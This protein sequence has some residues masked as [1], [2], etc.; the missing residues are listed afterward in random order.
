LGKG[1]PFRLGESF[2]GSTG[3]RVEAGGRFPEATAQMTVAVERARARHRDR[4]ETFTGETKRREE[5]RRR[6]EKELRALPGRPA[7]MMKDG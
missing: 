3:F 5:R 6:P 2:G 4:L 7:K 1:P